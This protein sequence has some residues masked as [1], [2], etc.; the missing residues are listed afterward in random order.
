[1]PE[2]IQETYAVGSSGDLV[3]V[4]PFMLPAGAVILG[5]VE[6]EHERYQVVKVPFTATAASG[7]LVQYADRI[8]FWAFLETTGTA[9]ATIRLRDGGDANAA[10]IVP[11]SLSAGESTRD[12]LGPQGIPCRA[13]VYLE[14]VSGSVEGSVVVAVRRDSDDMEAS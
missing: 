5:L 11:I 13:G 2:I 7:E 4:T 6:I 9:R 8:L 12:W 14:V 3:K 1:M 10:V